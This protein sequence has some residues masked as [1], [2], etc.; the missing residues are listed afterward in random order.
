MW[1]WN[2]SGELVHRASGKCLTPKGNSAA[3]GALLTLWTCTGSPVQ[4]WKYYQSSVTGF[5]G[6]RGADSWKFVTPKGTSVANGVH[7]TQ[8]DWMEH[9][10]QNWYYWNVSV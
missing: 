3:N 10:S 2:A 9:G 6:I 8:W 7:I 1:R 5:E 4:R